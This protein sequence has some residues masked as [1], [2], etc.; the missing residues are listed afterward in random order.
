MV[1]VGTDRP[2]YTPVLGRGKQ[3]EGAARDHAPVAGESNDAFREHSLS[4]PWNV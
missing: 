3:P 1:R 2:R 4:A